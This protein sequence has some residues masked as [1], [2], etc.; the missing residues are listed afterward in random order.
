MPRLKTSKRD[1]L[2]DRAFAYI[3][4]RG[5]RRLPVHDRAHVKNALARFNQVTF[6]SDAARE[7]ARK[8]LLNAAKKYGIVPVGFITGELRSERRH[9]TAG[10]LVIELGRNAAPGELQA[11]LRTVLRDPTL[12]VLHWSDASGA[13]LDGAGK[14]V[15]LPAD[16]DRRGVTYLERQGRPMTALVHDPTLLDDPDLAKTVLD[17]VRFV[18]EKDRLLG[19]VQ[20]TS[21]EAAALPTGFVTLMMTDIEASTA[22]LRKLG[23][24]YGA[25]LNDVR[26]ILRTAVSRAGGREIDARADEFFAVFERAAAALEAAVAIQ[27]EL[28]GRAARDD[29]EVRVRVGIHSGRPTLTDAGYIGLAVHTTARVCAAAHGG[30]IIASA[31]TRAAIATSAPSGIRFRSLGRH[32]LP[33]LAEA[34]MLFQVQAP[35][36][37]ASFPRPRRQASARR[38][39]AEPRKRPQTDQL[40]LPH[41]P[42]P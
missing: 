34:E 23:D 38:P 39:S 18:V 7:R 27:R 28:D 4:S 2:P 42:T 35:G 33:S 14:A 21:T 11:R 1:R 25:L 36:L 30:Q 12:T 40:E 17:A 37:R 22:L 9:A 20:A 16:G 26:G 29:V 10:R 6:E 31:A 13:Y 5:R 8:R 19:Q 15:S 24:H 3:D 32:R 41:S